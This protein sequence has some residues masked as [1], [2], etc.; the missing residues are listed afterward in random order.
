MNPADLSSPELIVSQSLRADGM[1][2]SRPRQ[3]SCEP[4]CRE[5]CRS[6][7]MLDGTVAGLL[8]SYEG[9]QRLAHD[10]RAR[11]NG[12]TRTIAEAARLLECNTRSIRPIGRIGMA[13]SQTCS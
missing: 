8:V 11:A 13:Q 4:C 1:V 7:A 5:S 6:L 10:E 12:D 3:I 2:P 9:F